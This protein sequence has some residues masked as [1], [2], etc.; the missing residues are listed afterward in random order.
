MGENELQESFS[1]VSEKKTAQLSEPLV[2]VLSSGLT[3]GGRASSL[4]RAQSHP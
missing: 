1:W 3:A 4:G 2:P